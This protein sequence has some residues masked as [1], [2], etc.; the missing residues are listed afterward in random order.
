MKQIKR[1][2]LLWLCWVLFLLPVKEVKAGTVNIEETELLSTADKLEQV[3][4]NVMTVELAYC[5]E[6]GNF[7]VLHAGSGFLIGD[8]ESAPQ[9]LLT[10]NQVV[11]LWEEEKEWLQNEE[12]KESNLQVRIVIKKDMTV[13]A[14][15]VTS[16]EEIGFALL[17]LEQPIYDRNCMVLNNTFEQPESEMEVYSIGIAAK[18][19]S[20]D[21]AQISR[22][23]L[24]RMEESEGAA[25]WIHDSYRNPGYAG[26]PLVDAEGTV[27]GLNRTNPEGEPLQATHITEILPVLDALGISY[28]TTAMEL[29]GQQERQQQLKEALESAVR[30]GTSAM[31]TIPYTK[32]K[33]VLIFSIIGGI[34][35]VFGTGILIALLLTREKRAEKRR[36]RQ[37]E[38][39]VTQPAPF[40]DRGRG[41]QGEAVLIREKTGQR[42]QIF[43]ERFLIGKERGNTDFYIGDNSAVSRRHACILKKEDEFY[44]IG[45]QTTNGTFLNGERLQP[46][47]ARPLGSG[48]RIRLADEDFEFMYSGGKG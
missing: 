19:E 2:G 34:L 10:D 36:K 35:L 18:T 23:T 7:S 9:Y 43:R 47:E 16:S 30:A 24:F 27:L 44:L 45:F 32:S 1:T 26:G 28:K 5:D 38:M 29:K 14:S 4:G 21:T 37:E 17:H 15:V 33:V 3:L 6:E 31:E 13:E 8:G 11:S 25:V 22:G 40:F 46:G 42:E 12:I 41:T 48:D 20:K 39:T